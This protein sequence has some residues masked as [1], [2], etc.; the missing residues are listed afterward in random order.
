MPVRYGYEKWL[1]R[2]LETYLCAAELQLVSRKY[3]DHY[4][5]L[6]VIIISSHR[7]RLFQELCFLCSSEVRYH[8]LLLIRM[9]RD[10]HDDG[11]SNGIS[12]TVNGAQ[13]DCA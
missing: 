1:Y 3:C 9:M 11:R 7:A 8:V 5:L 12:G 4:H 2:C 10:E 6:T 13:M